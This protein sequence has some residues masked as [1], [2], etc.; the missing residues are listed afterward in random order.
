MTGLSEFTYDIS[1]HEGHRHVTVRHYVEIEWELQPVDDD[2]AG[3][4]DTGTE[5]L[6]LI[7]EYDLD[8]DDPRDHETT[9]EFEE[10]PSDEFMSHYGG[11]IDQLKNELIRKIDGDQ[12]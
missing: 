3:E 8:I 10:H 7:S 5:D 9:W 2:G 1:T 6:V 11:T 4:Y 12:F